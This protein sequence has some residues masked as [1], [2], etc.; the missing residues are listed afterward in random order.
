MTPSCAGIKAQC[1]LK[2]LVSLFP[3]GMEVRSLSGA[4]RSRSAA[5]KTLQSLMREDSEGFHTARTTTAKPLLTDHILS[6]NTRRQTSSN[7]IWNN[8]EK[9]AWLDSSRLPGTFVQKWMDDRTGVS[10]SKGKCQGVIT[11]LN[12]VILP[13]IQTN[14]C[15]KMAWKSNSN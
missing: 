9:R 11:E 13:R 6:N 2:L 5:I 3:L 14:T 10:V 4:E 1:H 15:C 7:L 12:V 8:C